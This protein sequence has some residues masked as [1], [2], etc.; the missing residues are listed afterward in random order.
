L[1]IRGSLLLGRRCD[2]EGRKHG[3]EFELWL[4]EAVCGISGSAAPVAVQRRGVRPG[5]S[6]VS[7]SLLDGFSDMAGILTLLKAEKYV[8]ICILT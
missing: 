8:E 7:D 1:G 3:G 4:R 5:R 2:G 6:G